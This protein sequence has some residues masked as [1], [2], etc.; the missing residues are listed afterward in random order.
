[1]SHPLEVPEGWIKG[2]RLAKFGNGPRYALKQYLTAQDAYE[3]LSKFLLTP[4]SVAYIIFD[5]EA[6]RDAFLKWWQT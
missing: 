4:D 2:E 1:M 6:D 5:S 3:R